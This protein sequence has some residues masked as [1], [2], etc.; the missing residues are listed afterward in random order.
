MGSRTQGLQAWG[1]PYLDYLHACALAPFF[2]LL[3]GEL[4]A[5]A[6]D[7]GNGR[8]TQ[9]CVSMHPMHHMHATT[10]KVADHMLHGVT[11]WS[12]TPGSVRVVE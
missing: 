10:P 1:A 5:Q 7:A 4:R 8:V 12:P 2:G 6:V 9:A 3:E 11:A